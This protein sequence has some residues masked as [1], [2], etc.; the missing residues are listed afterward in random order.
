VTTS[1][2][3]SLFSAN[4]ALVGVLW[5]Q[6]TLARFAHQAC[7]DRASRTRRRDASPLLDSDLQITQHRLGDGEILG[8]E[9]GRPTSYPA[10]RLGGAEPGAGALVNYR[11]LEPSSA[12]NMWK[13]SRPPEVVLSI[14]SVSD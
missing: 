7:S 1:S 9:G 4:E 12:P 14:A 2:A 11:A 13:I 6:A 5:E 10:A 3:T 8:Q